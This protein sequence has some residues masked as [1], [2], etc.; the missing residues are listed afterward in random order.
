MS[1]LRSRFL[2]DENVRKELYDWL[3]AKRI[4]VKRSP[5]SLANGALARFSLKERRVLVINDSDF[6][7]FV[8]ESIFGVVWLRIPQDDTSTLLS[9]FAVLLRSGEPTLKGKLLT[10]W[11]GRWDISP[12]PVEISWKRS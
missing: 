1:S 7:R 4:D 3:I 8:R 5:R 12:L 11:P 2:L 10:L 6:T 9:S